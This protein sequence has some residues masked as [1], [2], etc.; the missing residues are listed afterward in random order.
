ME[1]F[2]ITVDVFM[3]LQSDIVPECPAA[4][5]KLTNKR[6]VI[7]F[8]IELVFSAFFVMKWKVGSDVLLLFAFRTR[9]GEFCWMTKADVLCPVVGR[10]LGLLA[11]GASEAKH[12]VVL[13][14]VICTA[15]DVCFHA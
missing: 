11:N 14:L 2:N 4:A 5:L 13:L 6:F 3:L 12:I 10:D 9:H 15:L 8:F 7:C 1:S